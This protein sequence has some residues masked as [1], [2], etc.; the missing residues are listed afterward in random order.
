MDQ[1]IRQ[2]IDRCL[3]EDESKESRANADSNVPGMERGRDGSFGLASRL[4]MVMP[5]TF[6][7]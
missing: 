1:D 6:A 2:V 4:R 5:S 7:I 3:T